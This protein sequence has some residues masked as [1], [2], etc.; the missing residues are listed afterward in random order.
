MPTPGAFDDAGEARPF[1]SPPKHRGSG[2]ARCNQ[3]CRV[4]LS[5]RHRPERDFPS[6]DLPGGRDDLQNRESVAVSK[7]ESVRSPIGLKERVGK[8]MRGRQVFDMH[9]VPDAGSIRR[10]VIGPEHAQRFTTGQY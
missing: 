8:Q 7:V 1:G 3:N 9:I 4:T 5:A 6:R 2:D 10:L